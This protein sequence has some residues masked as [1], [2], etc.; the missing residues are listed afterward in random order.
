[1]DGLCP[2]GLRRLDEY[3]VLVNFTYLYTLAFSHTQKCIHAPAFLFFFSSSFQATARACKSSI[4]QLLPLM[5]VARISAV[6][7]RVMWVQLPNGA[8]SFA[9]AY[10]EYMLEKDHF[11]WL[12]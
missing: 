12:V 3:V 9:I 11:R 4:S 8:R 10:N 7:S 5:M 6:T 1:M 2:P